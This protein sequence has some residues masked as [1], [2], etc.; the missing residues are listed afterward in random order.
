[1][2]HYADPR[3]NQALGIEPNAEMDDTL[4]AIAQL[5]ASVEDVAELR[6][7]VHRLKSE[8]DA[9]RQGF[10]ANR[11]RCNELH[12]E[13]KAATEERDIARDERARAQADNAVLCQRADAL[14]RALRETECRR[15][16]AYAVLHHLTSEF[17]P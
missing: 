6:E 13:L 17:V 1:M 5:R 12:A 3:V 9:A 2:S 15:D 14:D 7:A 4:A 11:D 8:R 16:S 10:I